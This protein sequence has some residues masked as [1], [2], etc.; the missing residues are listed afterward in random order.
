MTKSTQEIINQLNLI[1]NPYWNL[2]IVDIYGDRGGIPYPS[3]E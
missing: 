1:L 3:I 2:E